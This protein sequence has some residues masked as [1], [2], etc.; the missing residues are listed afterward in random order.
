[1]MRKHRHALHCGNSKA[2]TGYIRLITPASSYT[3]VN[4]PQTTFL[5]LDGRTKLD[6]LLQHEERDTKL[7][8]RVERIKEYLGKEE[9]MNEPQKREGTLEIQEM[10]LSK[11]AASENRLKELLSENRCDYIDGLRRPESSR[12][13]GSRLDPEEKGDFKKL[14]KEIVDIIRMLHLSAV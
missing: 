4:K 12:W 2:R 3:P 9:Y 1:M 10:F 5:C 13:R 14:S 11:L 6:W 8:A 7:R